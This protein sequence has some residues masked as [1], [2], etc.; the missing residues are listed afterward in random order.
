MMP[1]PE[2]TE[3]DAST[4]ET[5]APRR[6]EANSADEAEQERYQEELMHQ[7]QELLNYHETPTPKLDRPVIRTASKLKRMSRFVEDMDAL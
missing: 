2:G 4:L 7:I 6:G 5:A 1:R 3:V